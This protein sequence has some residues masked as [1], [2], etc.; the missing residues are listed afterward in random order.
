MNTLG[1][2]KKFWGGVA[3]AV[4]G[5]LLAPFAIVQIQ[6]RV[7]RH[8]AEQLLADMRLLMM[9]KADLPEIRSVLKRWHHFEP[10][11]DENDCWLQSDISY[12]S[13]FHFLAYHP[14]SEIPFWEEW[15]PPMAWLLP[16]RMY[17]GRRAHARAYA[18][19]MHGAVW[20]IVFQLDLE[21]SVPPHIH[22][23]N[24]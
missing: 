4:L 12:G 18:R 6:E 1:R 20:A 5:L 19:V 16:F 14:T 22:N 10:W 21:I 24:L 23:V 7:F 11:C 15:D 2:K 17:G 8:Q 13:F 3:L 9:H